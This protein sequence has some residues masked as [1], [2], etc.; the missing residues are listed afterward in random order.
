MTD[1]PDLTQHDIL[2]EPQP[3]QPASPGR[4]AAL[5]IG[6]LALL[7]GGIFGVFYLAGEDEGTP[8]DAVQ[9]M[10]AAVA[11]EDV[12]GMLAAL[13]PSERDPLRDNLTEMAKELRR[14]EVLAEDFD[15]A[16]IRGLDLSF[17]GVEMTG[18]PLGDGVSSV[19]ITKGTSSYRVVPRDL[20]LGRF[21]RDLLGDGLPAEPETGSEPISQD[22]STDQIVTIKEGGRW[23]VSV[24]YSI[25]EA[26]RL[27]SGAPVPKF[28]QG[29]RADGEASPEAAVEQLLRAGLALDLRRVIELLPPDEA[30]ALHDY[31]PLFL[32]DATAAASEIGFE[33]EWKSIELASR[34]SGDRATVT[35]DKLA[36]A[37]DVAG[38]RGEVSYDGRCVQ[39]AAPDVPPEESRIC[40]EDQELPQAFD[41][42]SRLPAQGFTVVER[43]GEWYVSPTRTVLE[44]L[45]G[46]LRAVQREDLEGIRQF[47]EGTSG[48]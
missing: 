46:V 2:P 35:I 10:L 38:E 17:E 18:T 15:L 37:F 14:L 33:A 5:W 23:Y 28:G 6:V 22:D 47:F 44:S 3:L 9:R 11:D 12:L 42:A 30:R 21:V 20:P 39:I 34:R 29:L 19:R 41:F 13:P 4:L 32:D 40:P 1:L 7:A 27:E 24:N 25:A 45:V 16:K 31:A 26:A 48:A 8:E 36:V 43:G